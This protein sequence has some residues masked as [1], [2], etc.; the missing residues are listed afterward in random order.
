MSAGKSIEKSF[1]TLQIMQVLNCTNI[2]FVSSP[3]INILSLLAVVTHDHMWPQDAVA[4]PYLGG[5]G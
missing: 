3:R 5:P 4:I 2:K 1:E